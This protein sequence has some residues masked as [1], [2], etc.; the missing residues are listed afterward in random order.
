MVDVAVH[1]SWP[2]RAGD[3]VAEL[4]VLRVE[5]EL[6]G[7]GGPGLLGG[8]VEAVADHEVVDGDEEDAGQEEQAAVPQG[9][10]E[11]DGEAAPALAFGRRS[12]SA[13][14]L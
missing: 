11:P 13:H 2:G 14:I 1:R 9:Q 7:D 6:L 4:E 12:T 10:L 5:A 8:G 3:D